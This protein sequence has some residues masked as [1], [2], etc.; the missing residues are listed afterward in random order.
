M[1]NFQIILRLA[2]AAVLS[3]VIGFEREVHGR[4]AGLRTHI[5]VC[6]GS[7]LIMLTSLYIFDIYI[8]RVSLDPTRLATGVITGIGFL[9]AGTII[10]SG[11]SIKGLTTAASIW[12]VAG[13]GLAVGC[14]FYI[15]A[16]ATTAIM[17]IALLFLRKVEDTVTTKK[18]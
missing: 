18:S 9:G 8:S 10:R 15:G 17:L 1:G 11:A 13:V 6:V 14:G 7:A 2:L 16:F 5:L 4:A 3:G 12:A